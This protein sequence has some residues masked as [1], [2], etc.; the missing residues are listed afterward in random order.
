[1][2]HRHEIAIAVVVIIVLGAYL[3]LRQPPAPPHEGPVPETTSGTAPSAAM[4]ANPPPT[5]PTTASQTLPS[6]SSVAAAR[7]PA[8]QAPPPQPVAPGAVNPTGVAV[9]SAEAKPE[10]SAQPLEAHI[11]VEAVRNAIQKYGAT[12]GGNP[13]GTNEEITK[14][15]NGNNPTHSQFLQEIP[16]AQ[17]DGN[18][19]L[20]DQWGTPY[21]FHQL[22]AT[23]MEVRSAGPDHIMWTSDD[24]I[25]K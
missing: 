10:S 15:L 19:N 25:L 23:D 12:F 18:G 13:V 16:G 20:L 22:S 21:F 5:Q 9:N 24:I 1:M 11:A 4:Q 7:T 6:T 3:L 2:R 14:A 8:L 17:I